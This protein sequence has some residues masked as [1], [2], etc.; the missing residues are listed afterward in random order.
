MVSRRLP[1]AWLWVSF[2]ALVVGKGGS[3]SNKT[4]K[5]VGGE[6]MGNGQGGGGG[7][8]VQC[9]ARPGDKFIS[10]LELYRLL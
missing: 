10:K 9:R 1:T 6:W 2:F 3:G 7:G 4:K 8:G 5:G